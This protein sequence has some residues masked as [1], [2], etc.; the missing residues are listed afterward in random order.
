MVFFLL[1]YLVIRNPPDYETKKQFDLI[2][3]AVD[4]GNPA[5]SVTVPVKVVIEDVNDNKPQFNQSSYNLVVS[6]DAAVR[7]RVGAVFATDKDSGVRGRLLYTITGGNVGNAFTIDGNTGQY[8]LSFIICST[9][10]LAPYWSVTN[11]HYCISQLV[12]AM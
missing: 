10:N 1:G 11:V 7:E 6:E 4:G 12:L 3:E 2:V 8:P 5:K 9:K